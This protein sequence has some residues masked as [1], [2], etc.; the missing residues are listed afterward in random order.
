MLH[1]EEKESQFRE[2]RTFSENLESMHQVLKYSDAGK[3][4]QKTSKYNKV[5]VKLPSLFKKTRSIT[6]SVMKS[7]HTSK[8]RLLLPQKAKQRSSQDIIF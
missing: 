3:K 1:L 5:T 6:V 2:I 4:K 7:L 8:Y